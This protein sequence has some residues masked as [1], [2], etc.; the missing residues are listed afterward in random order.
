M[1][2]VEGSGEI[3]I[4]ENTGRPFCYWCLKNKVDKPRIGFIFSN[5]DGKGR[6]PICGVCYEEERRKVVAQ[7]ELYSQGK[8]KNK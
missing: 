5:L 6:K 2:L 1:E 3:I 7:I 8:L 4:D